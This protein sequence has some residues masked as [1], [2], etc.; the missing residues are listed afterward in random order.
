MTKMRYN[1]IIVI[2]FGINYMDFPGG[3][4]GKEPACQFKKHKRCRFNPSVGKIPW[5][6]AWPSSP[7][8]F[9]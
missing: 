5:R 8:F 6:K 1:I 4:S 3:A 9:P 7:V 2:R